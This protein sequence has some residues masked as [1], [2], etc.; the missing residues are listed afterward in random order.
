MENNTQKA[1][2]EQQKHREQNKE[3]YLR[4]GRRGYEKDKER[5]QKRLVINSK[6]YLKKY[7]S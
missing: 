3:K 6:D 5:L 2:S 1:I 4:K 7:D